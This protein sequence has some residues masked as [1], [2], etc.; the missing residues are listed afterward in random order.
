MILKQVYTSMLLEFLSTRLFDII[1]I[2]IRFAWLIELW[3]KACSQF[4]V[5]KSIDRFKICSSENIL[6]EIQVIMKL[7]RMI[8]ESSFHLLPW[9]QF[10]GLIFLHHYKLINIAEIIQGVQDPQRMANKSSLSVCICRDMGVDA[11]RCCIQ[12]RHGTTSQ[13]FPRI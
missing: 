7:L 5:I 9:Q 2:S 10:L 4:C 13:I 12:N 11:A 6:K 3:V 1:A 8:G